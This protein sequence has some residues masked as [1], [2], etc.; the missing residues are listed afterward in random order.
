M[1][2][3]EHDHIQ[4]PLTPHTVIQIRRWNTNT[5]TSSCRLPRT[6]SYRSDAGTQT[7]THS[8]AAYPAHRHIDQTLEHEHRHI[9]LPLTPHTVIQIRRWTLT[10]TH[11]AAAYPA[12][13]HTDQ[14]LEHEH[15]HIQLPLTPHTVIQIR[16]WNMNTITFY[17][18]LPRTPSYRSDAATQ[19]QTHSAAAYPAHRHTDQTLEH[20]HDHIQLPLTPHTVIQIRRWNTN[21]DTFSCRLP[22][23]PSYRSD[24]GTQTQ[25][26]SA[27]AYPAHRHTDQTLEHKHRHIQLPLT[28]HTVIQIRRWNMNTITFSCR[29]PRTPSYRSDAGT[30]TQTHSAA[31]Y[32]AH[33]HTDQTLQHKHDHVQ[34]PLKSI[35]Y[36]IMQTHA[37]LDKSIRRLVRGAADVRE[38]KISTEIFV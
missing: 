6:P 27:A 12:H 19:T 28:P 4:L 3:H 18:R 31:A 17:C 14:T 35:I 29:L 36:L 38:L 37:V 2:E 30:Q 9:Q 33:R 5:D 8:A 22:R 24:A 10:Q 16:R 26:H 21:T 34:L 32:P 15:N 23:T 7:Q 20:E 1:L 13:R 11:S 25:T